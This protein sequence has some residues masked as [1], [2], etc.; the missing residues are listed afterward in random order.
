MLRQVADDATADAEALENAAI[1]DLRVDTND[2][3]VPDIAQE[4]LLRTGWLSHNGAE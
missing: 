4:I 3:S 1:G 2:R